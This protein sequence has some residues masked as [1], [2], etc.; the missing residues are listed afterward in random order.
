MTSPRRPAARPTLADVSEEELLTQVFPVLPVTDRLLVPPGDD[1][2]LLRVQGPGAVLTTDTMIRGTDWLDEWSSAADVG[3]K[4]VAQNL[5]DVAA[6]G[7]A[8]TGLTVTLI[9]D[10][11]TEV[12]WVLDFAAALGRAAA[13]AEVAVVGGDL[14]SAPA[15]V[16]MVSVTAVG[17]LPDGESPVLRS[18]ARAGDVVAVAGTLGTAA[19]G[20]EALRRGQIDGV[21][22]PL[23]AA[24]RTPTPPV[25]EGAA[26]RAA[27]AS[28]M[29]DL[30]DGLVRDAGRLAAA[31]SVA[32]HLDG[33][34]LAHDLERV[35]AVLGQETARDCVFGGGE[36][37]S[38][39]ATF[40]GALPGPA[41]RAI[42]EVRAGT[43]VWLDGKP[44][45]TGGW[46]HFGGG[47]GPARPA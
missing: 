40:P 41:W 20:L 11:A 9:A 37:H 39:L 1:A 28:S 22:A 23:V 47:P 43:G 7:A 14:S 35:A 25:A 26:A 36:E 13:S 31:S 5:A 46:D 38:L 34:E 29:I 30:S 2:A 15:G 12:A 8:P 17:E 27:G 4:V 42:G 18:G 3:A 44:A 24:Q 21:A 6:M 10:P 16:L 45:P 19:A 32:L 33:A